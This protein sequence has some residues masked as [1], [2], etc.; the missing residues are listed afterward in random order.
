MTTEKNLESFIQAISEP[1]FPGLFNPWSEQ[2]DHES[3]PDGALGRRERLKS[4]LSCPEPRILLIGEAAGYQGCRF[5]GIPFTS[6]RLLLEGKIPRVDKLASRISLRHRPWSEPSATIVWKTLDVLNLTEHVVLSNA[7]PWHPFG[8]R[9][10]LSNRTPTRYER[11]NGQAYLLLFLRL[12]TDVP[13]VALGKTASRSLN[14]LGVAH[15]QVRHPAYGGA[16][17]FR[18]GLSRVIS[19]QT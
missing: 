2:S 7:V 9:G 13:V 8:E 4:H 17:K 1:R 15:T 14:A 11:E 18:E 16:L 19:D 12:F 10:P 5:S 3:N 6:E